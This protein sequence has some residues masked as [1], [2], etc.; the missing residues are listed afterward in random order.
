ME[1]ANV[2]DAAGIL[3]FKANWEQEYQ[4]CQET[5]N[6]L[7]QDIA[8]LS[9]QMQALNGACQACDVF[10]EKLETN[11]VSLNAGEPDVEAP[12]QSGAPV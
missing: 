12:D 3:Q 8:T 11:S 10:L 6:K 5:I 9:N 4:R 7:Q 2:I 1:I